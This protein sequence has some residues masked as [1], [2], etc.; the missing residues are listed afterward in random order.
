MANT[1]ISAL[2]ANTN[3]NGWEELV[4]AYNNANGKMTLNTMKTFASADSQPLLVSWTN[5]KT[6][7]G[8]SIL[9]SWNMVISWWGWWWATTL[10]ADAN[11]WELSEGSYLTAYHLYYKTWETV[12]ALSDGTWRTKEQMIFVVEES[13]GSK[14]Y[15]VF[16][17]WNYNNSRYYAFAWFWYSASSSEWE[18]RQLKQ[19]D[20]SLNQFGYSVPWENVVDSL[21]DISIS[22]VITEMYGTSNLTV[23]TVRPPYVWM[24]YTIYIESVQSW[25]TYTIWLWTWVTN[26]FNITLPSSSNKK[27]LITLL[28]TSST[29]AIVTWCTIAS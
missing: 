3:P 17:V 1:K 23:S 10:N 20:S 22:Q 29:T 19:W 25:Q 21:Q 27:C 12:D 18:F 26:P 24:T 11:I 16:N 5:I 13:A 7:N 4:Y 14:W 8:D 9:W 15:F 2:T 6:I 28:I